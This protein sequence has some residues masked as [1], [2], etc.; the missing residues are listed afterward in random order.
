MSDEDYGDD[1]VET[2]IVYGTPLDPLDEESVAKKKKPIAIED[3]IVTDENGRRRFHGAFTG[4]FSAGYFNTVGTRDGWSPAHFKS[5]RGS[6]GQPSKE[7]QKPED[8]MDAE[9]LGEFGIAPQGLKT[10]AQFKRPEDATKKRK[11]EAAAAGAD[12]DGDGSVIP[13]RP[14]QLDELFRPVTDTVGVSLLRAMGWRPGQGIGPRLSRKQKA[15]QAEA[16]QRMFGCPLPPSQGD[17]RS[18]SSDD[19]DDDDSLDPKYRAFL[20]APD[21]VPEFLAKPKDNLFGIGYSGLDRS[22]LSGHISLFDE[23]QQQKG[24]TMTGAKSNRKIKF[25]G[26]A[27]GV[28]AYEDEDDDVYSRDHM[29]QY[30]FELAPEGEKGGAKRKG[31]RKRSRWSQEVTEH[32]AKIIEG[33]QLSKSTSTI[34]KKLFPPPELPKGFVPRVGVKKSRFEPDP[35][36]DERLKTTNPTPSQRQQAI[37]LP[38]DRSEEAPRKPTQS[39]DQIMKLLAAAANTPVT[40]M[41]SFKPFARDAEKQK[42]YE[43]YLV[44]V[45]NNRGDALDLLQPKT[46]TDWEKERERVEFERAVVMFR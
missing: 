8:F 36:L 7:M 11:R 24:L 12:G 13:G 17:K 27:F 19:D 28:G 38:K 25:S 4:G 3:Q 35:K 2:A 37:S 40:D 44:C 21:D 15:K 30:D 18:A 26:Q 9:D 45:K 43:K 1:E 6:K 33:F 20:F 29:E 32:V 46:M 23:P 14:V 34:R 5:S 39:D 16:N 42:R 22:T 41:E 10:S 31:E